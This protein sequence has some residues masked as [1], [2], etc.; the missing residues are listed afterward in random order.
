MAR[1]PQF[2]HRAVVS[3]VLLFQRS[4]LTQDMGGLGMADWAAS[5]GLWVS[6]GCLAHPGGLALCP[7]SPDSPTLLTAW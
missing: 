4:G 5:G 7:P 1:W 3:G 2:T 6:A